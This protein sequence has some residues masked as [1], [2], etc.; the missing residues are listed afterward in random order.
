M[1]DFQVKGNRVALGRNGE[2]WHAKDADLPASIYNFLN[3]WVFRA[4]LP[5]LKAL[6]LQQLYGQLLY[7]GT[8]KFSLALDMEM[9]GITL[10]DHHSTIFAMAHLY[11]ICRQ[12]E[13]IHGECPEPDRIIQLHIGQLFAGQLTTRPFE[14]H[15]RLSIRMGSTANAFVRNQKDRASNNVNI[16]LMAGLTGKGMKHQTKLALSE[17]SEI[18]PGYSGHKEPIEKP[19]LRLEAL[20]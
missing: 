15:T 12:T 2:Y 1:P 5:S 14:C 7:G 19:L 4:P 6:G 11:N 17:S 9:A 3:F 18:F 20:T 13:T 10:A 8:L 16:S